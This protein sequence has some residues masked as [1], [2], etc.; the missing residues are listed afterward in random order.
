VRTSPNPRPKWSF[1]LADDA[2]TAGVRR[3][4]RAA[5]T[6]R[7]NIASRSKDDERHQ[8]LVVIAA[9]HEGADDCDTLVLNHALR[10]GGSGATDSGRSGPC[11]A[12]DMYSDRPLASVVCGRYA[13]GSWPPHSPPDR[14]VPRNVSRLLE[15]DSGTD[16]RGNAVP[17]AAKPTLMAGHQ[18]SPHDAQLPVV[19]GSLVILDQ[20]T[21]P[22]HGICR[23]TRGGD[24]G[25]LTCVNDQDEDPFEVARAIDM[26]FD[27]AAEDYAAW[28]YPP[29]IRESIIRMASAMRPYRAVPFVE[30]YRAGRL[31]PE[32]RLLG[33]VNRLTDVRL[34]LHYISY[35]AGLSNREYYGPINAQPALRDSPMFTLR[36]MAIDQ[37]LIGRARIAW[38]K[39]MRF[40]YFMESGEEDLKRSGKQSYKG[41]FFAWVDDEPKWRWLAPY[42]SV[43]DRHDDLFRTGEY[44]KNSVLRP[45]ILGRQTP[46]NNDFIALTNYMS[47]VI[48]PNILLIASGA[49][50]SH[51]TDLHQLPASKPDEV[52]EIDPRYLPP[53]TDGPP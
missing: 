7:R 30:A 39:L 46:E 43:V 5:V 50:P 32:A 16:A 40:V 31:Y 35:D 10:V 49:W 26:F 47:N 17:S 45:R 12:S 9:Y 36:L 23:T 34:Q 24:R 42:K 3:K 29:D 51:F 11:S 19:S 48:S 15:I 25:R 52:G 6:K 28:W 1:A 4:M 14:T 33:C 53:S 21:A 18:S 20:P 44:H 37:S 13:S 38:E 22:Q 2:D 27:R 8:D 41:K